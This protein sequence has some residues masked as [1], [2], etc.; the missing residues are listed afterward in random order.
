VPGLRLPT[1]AAGAERV[2][3]LYVVHTAQRTALQQHLAARG[4]GTLVHY[5][6]PPHLQPAYAHLGLPAGAL[7]IA[8][9]LAATCLRLPLWPGMTEALMAMVAAVIRIFLRLNLKAEA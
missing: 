8:E 4:I 6:A 5:P 7:P 9:E 3:H 2:W 1:V